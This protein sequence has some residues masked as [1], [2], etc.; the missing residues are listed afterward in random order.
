MTEGK[1][2]VHRAMSLDGFIT[3]EPGVQQWLTSDQERTYVRDLRIAHDAV[4]VGGVPP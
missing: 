4:M 3:S 2:V 1:V